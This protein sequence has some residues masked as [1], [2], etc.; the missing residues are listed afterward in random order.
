MSELEKEIKNICEEKAKCLFTK[1]S[2]KELSHA[3][4]E[5]KRKYDEG[6]RLMKEANTEEYLI[7]N[8]VKQRLVIE[9]TNSETAST[10]MAEL[11]KQWSLCIASAVLYKKTY[12]LTN[13]SR[14]LSPAYPLNLYL[15]K[16]YS[17]KEYRKY[18]RYNPFYYGCIRNISMKKNQLHINQ[19]MF[20]LN[21]LKGFSW[22]DSDKV[23]SFI[24]LTK[25]LVN[26]WNSWNAFENRYDN[27]EEKK[28]LRNALAALEQGYI[29]SYDSYITILNDL[30]DIINFK[31]LLIQESSDQ[32]DKW[33]PVIKKWEEVNKNFLVLS[34]LSSS[35][36]KI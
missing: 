13:F 9:D 16:E 8:E 10:Q 35:K 31:K 17:I 25:D 29:D 32:I 22:L 11:S 24:L 14:S 3:V 20:D 33:R 5:I 26:M 19:Y 28:K 2:N 30:D 7:I 34:Q 12:P 27:D 15:N 21:V 1:A 6:D 36:I 18:S 23:D 4:K